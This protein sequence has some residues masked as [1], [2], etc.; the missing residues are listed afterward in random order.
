M[1]GFLDFARKFVFGVTIIIFIYGFVSFPDA[2]ISQCGENS[3]CD[4]QGQPH[5]YE[6]YAAY[7]RHYSIVPWL[8]ALSI[9]SMAYLNREKY[10]NIFN[11]K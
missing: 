3:Y 5:T 8:F 10:N 11:K 7:N 4:K 9:L 1:K 6:D 2:P